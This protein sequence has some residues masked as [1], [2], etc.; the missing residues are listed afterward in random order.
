MTPGGS[1]AFY[2]EAVAFFH[3]IFLVAAI[4]RD[5]QMRKEVGCEVV[6]LTAEPS[7]LCNV[8]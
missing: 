3:V 4:W 7:A 6:F 1:W 2:S 5:V 8:M